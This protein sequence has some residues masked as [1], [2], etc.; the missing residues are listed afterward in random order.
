MEDRNIYSIQQSQ[1]PILASNQNL[2]A[3]QRYRKVLL[4]MKTFVCVQGLG[5]ADYPGAGN[6]MCI[7]FNEFKNKKEIN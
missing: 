6:K 2:L 3:F 5:E 1:T 7:I 4:N